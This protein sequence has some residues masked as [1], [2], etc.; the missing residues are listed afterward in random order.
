MVKTNCLLYSL[1][2][3]FANRDAKLMA[4]WDRGLGF[5]HFYILHNGFEIHCEQK[6]NEDQWTFLFEPKIIK[7]RRRWKVI[8]EPNRERSV[9]T[10][11][12]QGKSS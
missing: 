1:Q 12:N 2:Y 7:I 10:K 11:F 6:Y 3:R 4:E 9:A 8:K 5:F